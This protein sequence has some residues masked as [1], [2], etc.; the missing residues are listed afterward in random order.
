[1]EQ[2]RKRLRFA[3]PKFTGDS[4]A[5]WEA[6]YGERKRHEDEIAKEFDAQRDAAMDQF[7]RGDHSWLATLDAAMGERPVDGDW[8]ISRSCGSIR[9][10]WRSAPESETRSSSVVGC[11]ART[12]RNA[13]RRRT[14]PP[15]S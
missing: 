1:M 13:V 4:L 14:Q 12:M 10:G 3:L 15:G 6:Y 7:D 9:R 5:D 2:P 11:R 8:P